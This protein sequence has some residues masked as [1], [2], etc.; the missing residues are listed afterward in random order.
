MKT[1]EPKAGASGCRFK[2]AMGSLS[3]NI[4]GKKLQVEPRRPIT[5]IFDML[6]VVLDPLLQLFNRL[7]EQDTIAAARTSGWPTDPD[8]CCCSNIILAGEGNF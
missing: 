8:D 3:T 5:I 1:L 2:Y 7:I 4:C 6:E